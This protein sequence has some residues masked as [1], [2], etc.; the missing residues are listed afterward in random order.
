MT[1]KTSEETRRKISR[2][3]LGNRNSVKKEIEMN[4]LSHD[5]SLQALGLFTLVTD[6]YRQMRQAEFALNRLLHDDPDYQGNVSDSI[7]ADKHTAADF[8]IALKHEGFEV[9]AP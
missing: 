6:L 7:Y 3:L 8:F 2:A 9:E 5:K 1:R 4:K